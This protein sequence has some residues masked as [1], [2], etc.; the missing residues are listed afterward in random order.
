MATD[1]RFTLSLTGRVIDVR[2]VGHSQYGNPTRA[3]LIETATGEHVELRTTANSQLAY[4][5]GNS[6]YRDNWHQFGLTRAGRLN[7][8]TRR[9][10]HVE[11]VEHASSTTRP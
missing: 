9:V 3:V 8:Y 1:N 7:G 4:G 6:E 11:H 5:I 2:T 10:E